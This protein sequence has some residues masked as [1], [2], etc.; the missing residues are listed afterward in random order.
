MKIEDHKKGCTDGMLNENEMC[1]SC[2]YYFHTF[3]GIKGRLSMCSTH[4]H[5]AYCEGKWL[6]KLLKKI[7]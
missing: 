2:Y 6:H 3:G 5:V 1:N 4:G 7:I